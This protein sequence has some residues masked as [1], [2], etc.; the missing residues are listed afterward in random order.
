MNEHSGEA[1]PLKKEVIVFVLEVGRTA[2]WGNINTSHRLTASSRVCQ[3]AR[4]P[5]SARAMFFMP[6]REALE[7]DKRGPEKRG[8]NFS[9]FG[10]L[11]SISDIH[12]TN[13]DRIAGESNFPVLGPPKSKNSSGNPSS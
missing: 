11:V 2:G 13:H 1:A 10:T 8:W 6:V 7:T 5:L 12:D 4:T 3:V 9:D